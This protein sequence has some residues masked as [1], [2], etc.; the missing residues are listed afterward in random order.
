MYPD[1][2]AYPGYTWPT[3]EAAKERDH[4]DRIDFILYSGEGVKP[5]S[6][7]IVGGDPR[8]ADLVVA[9][10]P[11]DHRAVLAAFSLPGRA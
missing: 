7:T 3:V 4:E 8:Y 2:M 1:E 5:H 10:Y 11:S 9:P 6:A